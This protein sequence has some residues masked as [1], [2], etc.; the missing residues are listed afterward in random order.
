MGTDAF[1]PARGGKSDAGKAVCAGCIVQRRC[2]EDAIEHGE[3]HG[4]WGGLSERGRRML[5]RGS[6]A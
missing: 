4:I 6:A 5:R 2:L 1:F 3:R